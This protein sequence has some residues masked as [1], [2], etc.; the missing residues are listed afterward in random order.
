MN[1]CL[2]ATPTAPLPIAIVSW[3]FETILA[4]IICFFATLERLIFPYIIFIS[5]ISIG[6]S[7]YHYGVAGGLLFGVPLGVVMALVHAIVIV[8]AMFMLGLSMWIIL[9]PLYFIANSC[10]WTLPSVLEQNQIVSYWMQQWPQGWR[11]CSTRHDVKQADGEI[12]AAIQLLAW[13]AIGVLLGCW[14]GE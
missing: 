2:T 11:Q 14:L 12:Q 4:G 1:N 13:L 10:R 9:L 7:I 5:A 3:F 8:I 6:W